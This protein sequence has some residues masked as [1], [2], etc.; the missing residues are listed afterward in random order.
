MKLEL[1][2]TLFMQQQIHHHLR[3]QLQHKVMQLQKARHPLL[4]QQTL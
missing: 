1:I 2:T 4:P 3:R